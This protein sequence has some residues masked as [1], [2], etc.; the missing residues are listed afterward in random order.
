MLRDG[1]PVDPIFDSDESLY[2]RCSRDQVDGDRLARAAIGFP[3]WS[4]NRG[5]YSEPGDV[6]LPNWPRWGV[7]RFS[8]GDVP[9]PIASP[10]GPIY[11]FSLEHV[12]EDHNYSHSEVR[13]YRNGHHERKLEVP[14][15]VKSIFRQKLSE[16]TRVI[17][18]PQV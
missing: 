17:I 12:P 6:C 7:A 3:D 18:E 5:R 15:T 2:H 11:T 8:V 10:G 14:K 1:R 4:V 13:A 16:K 9:S